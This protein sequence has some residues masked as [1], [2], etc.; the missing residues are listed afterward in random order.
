M[1]ST[2][3]VKITYNHDFKVGLILDEYYI[4]ET[5]SIGLID[6]NINYN[7]GLSI[8]DLK[9]NTKIILINSIIGTILMAFIFIDP[10]NVVVQLSLMID[11]IFIIFSFRTHTRDDKLNKI[12]RKNMGIKVHTLTIIIV[13]SSITFIVLNFKGFPF[14]VLMVLLAVG[15]LIPIVLVI[16]IRYQILC[17]FLSGEFNQYVI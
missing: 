16:W 9:K 2:W 15:L 14:F 8:V 17:E 4:Q 6:V 11:F 10:Q 1:S 3:T 7:N 5:L 12:F 13:L